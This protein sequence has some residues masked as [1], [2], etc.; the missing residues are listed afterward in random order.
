MYLFPY[1]AQYT[2][3]AEDAW[4]PQEKVTAFLQ[5]HSINVV[6]ARDWFAGDKMKDYFLFA[7]G[8]HFS[9]LGHQLVFE[10]IEQTM[11]DFETSGQR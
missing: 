9:E 10:R 11:S 4:L 5:E 6:D 8:C 3:A 7:D 2:S 1:V